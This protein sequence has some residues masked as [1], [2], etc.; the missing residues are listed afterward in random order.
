MPDLL[1]FLLIYI[2]G[3]TSL[4]ATLNQSTNPLKKCMFTGIIHISVYLSFNLCVSVD[5]Y[6]LEKKIRLNPTCRLIFPKPAV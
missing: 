2:V 5:F 4:S 3:Q 6:C 1:F